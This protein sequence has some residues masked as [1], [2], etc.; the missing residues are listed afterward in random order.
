MIASS[1][2]PPADPI[3]IDR[4]YLFWISETATGAPLFLGAVTNPAG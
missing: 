2:P 4:P 1:A 3:V